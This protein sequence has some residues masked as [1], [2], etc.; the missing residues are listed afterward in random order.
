MNAFASED[1][2]PLRMAVHGRMYRPA[3][4]LINAGADVNASTWFCPPVLLAAADNPHT[5]AE[6][7]IRLLINSG[8]NVNMTSNNGSTALMTAAY[9]GTSPAVVTALIDAGADVNM[10]NSYGKSAFTKA[11]QR[12]FHECLKLLIETADKTDPTRSYLPPLSDI[13]FYS[14][15]L[16]I[17]TIKLLLR[18][19]IKINVANVYFTN[20][21][22]HYIVECERF[23][24]LPNKDICMLLF[25]AG[26]RVPGPV[27]QGRTP[28]HTH[29]LK[30][31]VPEY[32]LHKDLQ[33]CLK[34]LCRE[35]IRKHP[36]SLDPQTHL[37]GR[38]PRLGLPFTLTDYLLYNQT[39]DNDRRTSATSGYAETYGSIEFS[40]SG[41][42]D[43]S[44]KHKLG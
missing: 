15:R 7:F 4:S 30:A 2:N 29:P 23:H 31:Q 1:Q 44:L 41:E 16:Q 13:E 19:G 22:T 38:V 18:A 10:R 34:H 12:N 9:R 11:A 8:A 14:D 39:L 27:V 28:N 3:K 42:T 32:L 37:F 33:M 5:D 25:A 6:K 26:E 17:S 20:T 24:N 40:E 43:K 35:S 36:L 21:M